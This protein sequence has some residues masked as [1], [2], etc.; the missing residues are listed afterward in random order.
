LKSK[1]S[2][3]P[4]ESGG[5]LSSAVSLPVSSGPSDNIEVDRKVVHGTNNNALPTQRTPDLKWSQTYELQSIILFGDI[6]VCTIIGLPMTLK[7]FK[8]LGSACFSV[9][10]TGLNLLIIFMTTVQGITAVDI[11]KK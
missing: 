8:K 5:M 10:D 11:I 9:T 4:A 1:P 6:S 2:K 3:K 7:R